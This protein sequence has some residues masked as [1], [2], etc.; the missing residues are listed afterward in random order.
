LGKLRIRSLG[1]SAGHNGIDSIIKHLRTDKFIRFRLG[2]GRG[3][4]STGRNTDKNIHHRSVID[5]V[6]SRFRQ[7]EAGEMRKLIK[8]GVAAVRIA[9][10]EGIDRAMNRFN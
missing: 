3:R 2:I 5:F 4:E 10:T 1:A 8:Y 6:L 9:I 7:G